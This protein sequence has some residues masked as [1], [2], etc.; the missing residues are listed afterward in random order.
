MH[1]LAAAEEGFREFIAL[2][3]R[4]AK[5]DIRALV[6]LEGPTTKASG[7]A[8]QR[9]I[10]DLL[11]KT[12]DGWSL[13]GFD[14]SVENPGLPSSST[15]EYLVSPQL[16]ADVYKNKC[17]AVLYHQPS[18]TYRFHS[19]SHRRVAEEMFAEAAAARGAAA[20]MA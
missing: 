9:L 11:K 16:V 12:R 4:K 8:F 1:L 15:D 19:T 7:P 6:N 20:A 13:E 14:G 5:L 2:A 3:K 17:H 18:D 10:E